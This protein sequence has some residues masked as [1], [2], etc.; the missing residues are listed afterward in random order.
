[1]L[2]TD[3]GRPDLGSFEKFNFELAFEGTMV[4]R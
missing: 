1:M 3:D 2:A 4:I